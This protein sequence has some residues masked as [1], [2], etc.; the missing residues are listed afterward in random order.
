MGAG[1]PIV[2]LHGLYGNGGNWLTAAKELAA[3]TGADVYLPDLRNHGRSPHSE[4]NSY[5]SMSGDLAEFIADLGVASVD[6][7]GHSMG[8][9]VALDYLRRTN[10]VRRCIAVDISPRASNLAAADSHYAYHVRAVRLMGSAPMDGTR[11]DVARHLTRGGVDETTA[12]FLMQN[13]TG[14][15]GAFEWRINLA[16]IGAYLEEIVYGNFPGNAAVK[17]PTLFVKGGLSDYITDEDA[18][19]IKEHFPN[20]TMKTIPGASHF[21][22]VERREELIKTIAEWLE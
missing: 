14:Q 5:G 7:V 11:D 15:A 2:I 20:G 4:V 21:V 10:A 12:L 22:H 8:G 16:A 19:F 13:L 3:A 18:L 1:V 17:T 9:R 6:V